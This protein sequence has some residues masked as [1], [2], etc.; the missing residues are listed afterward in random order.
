MIP[1]RTSAHGFS[2]PGADMGKM[3]AVSASLLVISAIVVLVSGRDSE[4]RLLMAGGSTNGEPEVADSRHSGRWIIRDGVRACDGYL[5]RR[6]DQ[7][8]CESEV[9]D[10]WVPFEFG[11]RTYYSAPLSGKFDR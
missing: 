6:R 2:G 1:K 3:L 4:P 8:F 9:P 10:D 11:G 5:T 7:D